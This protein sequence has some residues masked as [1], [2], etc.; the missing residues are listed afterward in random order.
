LPHRDL[1]ILQHRDLAI[2]NSTQDNIVYTIQPAT[3]STSLY[4]FAHNKHDG[5]FPV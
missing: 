3:C 2:H 4:H 5:F 1:A